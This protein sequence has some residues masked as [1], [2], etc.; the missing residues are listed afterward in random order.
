MSLTEDIYETAI[1]YLSLPFYARFLIGA[2]FK[3]IDHTTYFMDTYKGDKIIF[4]A[5]FKKDE[6]TNF[7]VL[8]TN[9]ANASRTTS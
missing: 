4:L 7:K 3:I 2:H 1:E 5:V 9:Y 6:Y 8:V